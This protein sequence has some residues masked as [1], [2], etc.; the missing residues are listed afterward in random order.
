MESCTDTGPLTKKDSK[1]IFAFEQAQEWLLA[2][3]AMTT[4]LDEA[5]H[6]AD[7]RAS[8]GPHGP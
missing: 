8:G 1:L 7:M 5:A 2:P 3:G 6:P 4:E